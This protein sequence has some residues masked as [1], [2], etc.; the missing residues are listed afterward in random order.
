MVTGNVNKVFSI[1]FINAGTRTIASSAVTAQHIIPGPK[2]ISRAV[3]PPLV[4]RC[5]KDCDIVF[6]VIVVVGR[7]RVIIEIAVP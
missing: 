2:A 3:Y 6:S 4:V 5:R 7:A 1:H